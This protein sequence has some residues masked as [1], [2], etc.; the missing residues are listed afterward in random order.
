MFR[1]GVTQRFCFCCDLARYAVEAVDG[2]GSGTYHFSSGSDVAII[3]LYDAVVDA[4]NLN[5]YPE[6]DVRKLGPDDAASI[7]LDPSR[8]YK[9]FG[10]IAFTPLKDTV[11][12]GVEYY[13]KYGVYGGYTH[14]K[15]DDKK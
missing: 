6:P 7:L 9:D 1:D 3:D 4:M 14:L 10:D 5:A 15:H 13:Q 8:T 2:K 12:L 11:R